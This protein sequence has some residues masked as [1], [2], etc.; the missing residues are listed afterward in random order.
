MAQ[1]IFGEM[2]I[3]SPE[4]DFWFTLGLTYCL[5]LMYPFP[6]CQ[7]AS[8]ENYKAMSF[9]TR[10]TLLTVVRSWSTFFQVDLPKAVNKLL[11]FAAY[12]L[13]R[14]GS[15]VIRDI[16]VKIL[17]EL[18][19]YGDTSDYHKS[20]LVLTKLWVEVLTLKTRETIPLQALC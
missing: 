6:H 19:A 2:T 15:K 8:C 10:K 12:F 13:H 9:S 20:Y 18:L 14:C 16:I 17:S 11:E 1:V 4:A 3:K 7:F 5:H